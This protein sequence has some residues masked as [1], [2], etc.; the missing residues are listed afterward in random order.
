MP[1]EGREQADVKISLIFF[2]YIFNS[3]LNPIVVLTNLDR[4]CQETEHET[5][6]VFHSKVVYAKVGNGGI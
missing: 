4:I 3:D 6:N 1:S 2:Y 5:T